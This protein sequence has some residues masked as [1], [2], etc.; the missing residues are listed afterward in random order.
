[1]V[2]GKPRWKTRNAWQHP[3]LGRSRPE[4]FH[5]DLGVRCLTSLV[6]GF[7]RNPRIRIGR[8]RCNGY[9]P[10]ISAPDWERLSCSSGPSCSSGREQ[11]ICGN[12]ASRAWNQKQVR[13]FGQSCVLRWSNGVSASATVL[14]LKKMELDPTV[15]YEPWRAQ[16][17]GFSLRL[18]EP[19][20]FFWRF[21]DVHSSAD[22]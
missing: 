9:R 1:M 5:G 20:L 21:C 12:S 13:G 8:Y 18:R 4:R 11:S 22:S 15:A 3:L 14:V 10:S 6:L 2:N 17:E 16:F 7:P 19:L